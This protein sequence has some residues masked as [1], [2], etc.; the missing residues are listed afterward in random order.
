MSIIRLL[1]WF[2]QIQF[3]M[4]QIY[5]WL[6][7]SFVADPEACCLFQQ[8][9]NDK[10]F[11]NHHL[12]SAIL[13][14]LSNRA[15]FSR[16]ETNPGQMESMLVGLNAFQNAHPAPSLEQALE[17]ALKAEAD[18]SKIALAAAVAESNPCLGNLLKNIERFGQVH[19]EALFE[20]SFK[21]KIPVSKNQS[22]PDSSS[23]AA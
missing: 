13:H 2:Q 21:R 12:K 14:S 6:S 15:G 19:F 16:I 4:K 1:F 23:L 3:K 11:Y 20:F 17:F 10:A 9:S 18:Q 22:L 8:I 7:L 5:E